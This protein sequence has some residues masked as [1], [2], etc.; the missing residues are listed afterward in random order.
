M[1]KPKILSVVEKNSIRIILQEFLK[2]E[3]SK[4]KNYAV[5]VLH[6]GDLVGET[7]ESSLKEAKK[8]FKSAKKSYLEKKIA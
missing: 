8:Q 7:Y 4:L 2:E 6:D 5:Y 3:K 1:L